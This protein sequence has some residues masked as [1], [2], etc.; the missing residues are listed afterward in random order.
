M[1]Y[2]G[3]PSAEAKQRQI[4]FG[5]N[6]IE[7]RSRIVWWKILL[8]QFKSPL[9]Y[10]LVLAAMATLWLGK[11]SDALIIMVAVL[12]NTLLGFFQEYRAEKSL[13]S[14]ASLLEPLAK[15]KRDGVW[16]EVKL[17]QVVPGD[18]LSL[19]IGQAV[20]ADG[21]LAE[22]KYLFANEA[23]LTGE[24]LPVEKKVLAG[25]SEINFADTAWFDQ[26]GEDHK[27]Y[28]GTTVN[29]GI[30]RMIAV[31]IGPTTRLGRIAQDVAGVTDQTTPLQYKIR[32]LSQ[33]L[34]LFVA[35][36]AFGVF[37]SG[38]WVG[39]PL[40]EI[41]PTAIALAVAAIPE[42]L[43]VSLTLILSIGMRRILK[44]DG[45]VRQ[46]LAAETLGGVDVICLDKTGTITEGRMKTLGAVTDLPSTGESVSQHMTHTKEQK[47]LDLLYLG[48]KLCNDMRDPLEIAMDS[49]ASEKGRISDDKYKRLDSLPFD[50]HYKYIAT[51][52][53]YKPSG[54]II[55]FLSGAP[56]VCLELSTLSQQEKKH[57]LDQISEIGIA[58]YRMVGFIHRYPSASGQV[59]DHNKIGKYKWLGVIIFE[60]PIRQGVEISL[61]RAVNAGIALKV[62]TGDYKETAWSVLKELGLVTGDIDPQRVVTGSELKKILTIPETVTEKIGRAILFARTTP[63]QKL[64]IVKALQERGHIVAMTGDGVNDAPA[65]RQADIGIVLSQASDVARE[66]ADLV[67]LKNNFD[68]I[69][70]AVEE[71]RAIFANL[72]RVLLYLMSDAFAAIV[73]VII[74]TALRWPLPI[75]AIQILWINLISDG[76]PYL[77]LTV[78]PKDGQ[79]MRQRPTPRNAPILNRGMIILTVVI[80]TLTG[81]L[82]LA[83]FKYYYFGLHAGLTLSRSA[84][85]GALGTMTLFYV[86]SVR[87]M[88]R[89]IWQDNPF[90]NPW[91]LL[92]TA[93]GF[94]TQLLVMYWQ[95]LQFFFGIRS[96]GIQDWAIIAGA[97]LLL[98]L[99]VEL[100]KLLLRHTPFIAAPDQVG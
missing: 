21:I 28:M 47:Q 99:A 35:L 91:L 48:A 25:K 76:L 34:A 27:I 89:N 18:L 70:A 57:W 43:L 17:A 24:S 56:E 12:A 31:R 39:D 11:I 33:K 37:L 86:Y 15:V 87:S 62:I 22:A 97:T 29:G 75:L 1:E 45:L 23:I 36:V 77:A 82:C 44:R 54:K 6:T 59:L 92:G 2:A 3:L 88:F 19:E 85:F 90:K 4:S 30:G 100:I 65:L 78:E 10:I 69:L 14:L 9:I 55:E 74:T 38:L 49:W 61:K 8:A 95:P 83:I 68:S 71:G 41:F 5:P 50:H 51:R 42:G 53:Q 52:H 72:Q 84:V 16:Q 7:R 94:L 67:L 26:I 63:E 46:L 40:S 32:D 60:D 66:T 96:L 13:E 64:A 81:I 73:L 20:P 80:S 58:G 79:L 98:I 93:A